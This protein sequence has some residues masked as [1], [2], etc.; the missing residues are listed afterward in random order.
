MAQTGIVL[1]RKKLIKGLRLPSSGT[2]PF[3]KG[4]CTQPFNKPVSV[5]PTPGFSFLSLL[6]RPGLRSVSVGG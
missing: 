3:P 5:L 6:L 2:T 1:I 4:S